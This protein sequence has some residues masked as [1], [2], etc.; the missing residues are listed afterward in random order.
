MI[1][2]FVH[3][4]GFDRSLW[5]RVVALL[6]E[7]DCRREDRGY[8]G[9][10]VEAPIAGE[11]LAVTHSLGT[12]HALAAPAPECRGMLAI[13]GFDRFAAAPDFP[14]VALRVLDRM[15]QRLAAAPAAVVGE[16]R[17]RCGSPPAA[18]VPDLLRLHCDLLMLRN[19][20]CHAGPWL[21][22]LHT[23]EADDDPLLPPQM[24]DA[25]FASAPQ[26][27]RLRQPAGRHLLPLTAPAACAAAIRD[28]L[29]KL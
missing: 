5:D 8:F 18:G 26:R 7:H 16:F 2:R 11:H 29:D 23:L 1:I 15:L 27:L 4:W 6:P 21:A 24:R 19:M 14:G 13:N 22:P 28:V 20:D 12:L 25:L 17:A 3:G 9:D 10:S